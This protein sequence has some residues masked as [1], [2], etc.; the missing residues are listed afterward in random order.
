MAEATFVQDGS[1]VDYT[2]ASAVAAGQVVVQGDLVGV[3]VQA[4]DANK[5]GAIAVS[6]V[7]D[8]VKTTGAIS[9]GA[10]VYWD[11]TN[12]YATTSATGTVYMGKAV[13]AAASADATVRVRLDQ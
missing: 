13:K 3:A 11:D 9:A 4:I 12:N 6:G 10:K 1:K 5:L 7:F 2:P 8:V